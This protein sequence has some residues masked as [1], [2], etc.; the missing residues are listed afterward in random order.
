MGGEFLED[1]YFTYSAIDWRGGYGFRMLH[2]R[3][4]TLDGAE[5][6]SM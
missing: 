5:T 2:V 6:Y 3:H 4:N 1:F